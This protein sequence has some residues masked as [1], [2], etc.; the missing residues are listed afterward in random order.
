M[1]V[2]GIGGGERGRAVPAHFQTPK[3]SAHYDIS[4]FDKQLHEITSRKA[5]LAKRGGLGTLQREQHRG[6]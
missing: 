3:I 2:D 4:A 1:W 6:A 5:T